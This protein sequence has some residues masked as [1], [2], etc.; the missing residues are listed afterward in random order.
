MQGGSHLLDAASGGGS[1]GNVTLNLAEL[2][3]HSTLSP[4]SSEYTYHGIGTGLGVG[5]HHT[6]PATNQTIS[7]STTTGATTTAINTATHQSMLSE[8]TDGHDGNGSLGGVGSLG[9]GSIYYPTGTMFLLTLE[10]LTFK[11]SF[12]SIIMND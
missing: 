2:H 12:L 1:I 3:G 9:G 10:T 4:L 11:F 7:S 8:F 6:K 5:V